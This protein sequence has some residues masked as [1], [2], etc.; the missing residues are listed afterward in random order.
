VPL[1]DIV[2]DAV[3]AVRALVADRRHELAITLPPQPI[4]LEADRARLAQV[5]INLLTNAAKYTEPGG[6]ITVTAE[7]IDSEVLVRLRDTGV[8]IAPELLPRIFD[9]FTQG[10]S[11]N[12]GLGLGLAL[13]RRLVE[14]HGGRVEAHSDG[15]G[16]GSEFHLRLPT[17]APLAL[18]PP[19]PPLRARH[20]AASAVRR[21]LVVDDNADCAETLARLLELG[22][23]PV[24]LAHDGPT[25]LR[26]AETFRPDVVL[27][28]IGLPRM[29]GYEVARRLRQLPGLERTVLVAL[30][31]YS[32]DEHRQR[33]R[34]VGFDQVLT[35]PVD[36]EG[37]QQL[38]TSDAACDPLSQPGKL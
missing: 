29:D 33:C 12:G 38:L 28:D 14:M 21:I 8:G 10:E 26:V 35:K 15:P 17:C 9:L 30:T 4:W 27:L 6:R 2:A 20:R 31:G 22:G 11:P 16:H 32:H 7:P 37:L 24:G 19:S 3:E 1:A 18:P 34:E 13:V 36:P 25:A 5:L 23:H